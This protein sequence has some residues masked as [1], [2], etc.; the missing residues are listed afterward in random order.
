MAFRF[1]FISY[2]FLSVR[3]RKKICIEKLSVQFQVVVKPLTNVSAPRKPCVSI[4]PLKLFTVSKIR[5]E[6]FVCSKTFTHMIFYFIFKALA[7]DIH[8]AYYISI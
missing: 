8:E 7:A 2:Q 3:Q 5:L 6:V 4:F 1:F